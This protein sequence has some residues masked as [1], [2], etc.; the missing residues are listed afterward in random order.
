MAEALRPIVTDGVADV[1]RSRVLIVSPVPTHPGTAGN[2]V[3]IRR[4][5]EAMISLGHHVEFAHITRESGDIE[6][7][8]AWWGEGYHAV[9]YLPNGQ[10]Q[11]GVIDRLLRKIRKKIT[12]NLSVDAWYDPSVDVR[13][14]QI[15]QQGAFDTVV[16]E[17]VFMSKALL[18]MGQ[19]T[20]KVIDTHD[21]FADRNYRFRALGQGSNWFST[22]R[23]QERKGLHRADQIIAIQEKEA[24]YF[25]Q[26]Q[27]K[28]VVTIG[29]IIELPVLE[30][31]SDSS[32]RLNQVLLVGSNNPSNVQAANWL[33]EEVVPLVNQRVPDVR[34]TIVGGV[35]NALKPTSEV[36]FFDFVESLADFFAQSSVVVNPAQVGT[37]LKIKTI[38]AMSYAK[39]VVSTSVGAEGLENGWQSALMVAD[40]P[41]DFAQTLVELLASDTSAA[42]LGVAGRQF[43]QTMNEQA[44]ERLDSMLLSA[45]DRSVR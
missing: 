31:A 41:E 32:S 39:A 6:A 43:V 23:A 21:V 44:L 35:V 8:K 5:A 20:L 16:V 27:S 3:R 12:N 25:R 2:R 38:E 26:L 13:L 15:L 7:M 19:E 4:L 9:D 29:D 45:V 18:C 17:Y 28:P 10:W 1:G 40:S 37:G 24:L 42:A 33:L 14:Q 11:L 22:S 34:W 30:P 36:E